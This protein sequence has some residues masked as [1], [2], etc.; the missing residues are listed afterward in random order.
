MQP[1]D[2]LAAFP[3]FSQCQLPEIIVPDND[4]SETELV[5]NTYGKSLAQSKSCHYDIFQPPLRTQ[6][7]NLIEG[8]KDEYLKIMGELKRKF[9][10]EQQFFSG[11]K[12]QS[13]TQMI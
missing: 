7:K 11:L 1:G 3:V 9:L 8:Q 2:L 12:N 10:A 13:Q 6:L 5:E 4:Q